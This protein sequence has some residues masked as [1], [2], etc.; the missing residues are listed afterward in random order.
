MWQTV[1][2]DDRI[3]WICDKDLEIITLWQ[4][5]IAEKLRDKQY[6]KKLRP[7]EISAALAESTRR[8][9]LLKWDATDEQGW[10]KE[11]LISVSL[12]DE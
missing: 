7:W 3:L 11:V 6:V 9:T 5:I 8:Y 10:L 1:T 12:D 2:K 4:Q